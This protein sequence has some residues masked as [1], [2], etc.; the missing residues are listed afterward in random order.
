MGTLAYRLTIYKP[1]SGAEE[2]LRIDSTTPFG[3]MRE[4]DSFLLDGDQ[5]HARIRRIAHALTKDGSGSFLQTTAVY[6]G[7]EQ[8]GG[9]DVSDPAIA[10]PAPVRDEMASTDEF[11]S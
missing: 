1:T 6:L 7:A 3:A 8:R 4:G 2:M 10:P 5:R 11:G 9:L